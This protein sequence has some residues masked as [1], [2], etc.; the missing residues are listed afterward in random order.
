MFECIFTFS[1]SSVKNN[2]AFIFNFYF[3]SPSINTA[4]KNGEM[5]SAKLQ[6]VS[7]GFGTNLAVHPGKTDGDDLPWARCVECTSDAWEM[8]Q[9]GRLPVCVCEPRERH[10]PAGRCIPWDHLVLPSET[11]G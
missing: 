1:S 3:K 10:R 5:F 2:S 4:G 8:G 11:R 9:R 7:L 6:Q